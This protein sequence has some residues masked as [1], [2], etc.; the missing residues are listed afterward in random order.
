MRSFINVVLLCVLLPFSMAAQNL[1][2][3]QSWTVG[4]GSTGI[5]QQNGDA[6]QNFREMGTNPY[7]AQALLWKAVP[8][9]P[10]NTA[11]GGWTTTNFPIDKTKLYR[12]AVWIKKTGSG[13][14][15]T[16]FGT[17]SNDLL[18]LDGTINTNAYFWYGDLP[19]LN[20][21]YLLVGYIHPSTDPSTSSYGGIYDGVS[22]TK[23]ASITDFRFSSNATIA[24]H[25]AYLYYDDNI[26]NRQY[27][28]APEAYQMSDNTPL[29]ET[30]G[31][32]YFSG[33]AFFGSKVGIG[34]TS[35]Q[36]P[37]EIKNSYNGVS[38]V[39]IN[40]PSGNAELRFSHNNIIKGF[41]WYNEQ[42]DAM[43]F[44]RGG[45]ANSLFVNPT[46]HV[47]IGTMTPDQKLSVKGKIHAEEV[48]IDLSVPGP[49]YV[50]EKDYEL[51]SLDD[52]KSY[53]DEHKHLPEVPSAK[54]MEKDGVKVGEM[55]MILLKKIEEI[56]LHLIN[57]NNEVKRLNALV[58]D[59]AK[60]IQSLKQEMKTLDK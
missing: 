5:F 37:L 3:S 60:M 35:P 40:S 27:F 48:I 11:D 36:S 56:T 43:S 59:Q 18:N 1:V 20:K 55:E 8:D 26:S 25:R 57:Q 31:S 24:Q 6:T 14:G 9:A 4:S 34:T 32:P 17:G 28:Y 16:Y 54:E 39:T 15:T 58:L 47:G 23:I 44:G 2:S 52:L 19:E 29:V 42:N 38:Q 12:F 41:V 45:V 22:G 46:G 21:W 10:Y 50:F 51:L 49:D 30:A 13:S 7:G 33:N 53:M